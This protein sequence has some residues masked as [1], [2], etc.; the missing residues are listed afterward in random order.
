MLLR[1][2]WTAKGGKND[3][4]LFPQA[5]RTV[6]REGFGRD[7]VRSPA[8]MEGTCAVQLVNACCENGAFCAISRA[9]LR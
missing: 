6:M 7:A 2:N 9:P 4:R 1:A 8:T 3:S 5:A